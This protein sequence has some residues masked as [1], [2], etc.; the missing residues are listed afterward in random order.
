MQPMTSEHIANEERKKRLMAMGQMAA[1]LAHEIRNPLGSVE[2]YCSLLRKDLSQHPTAFQLVNEI[3][4]GIKTVDRII[5]NCL[6]FAR[7]VTPQKRTINDVP[8][9]LRESI[10]ILSPQHQALCSISCDQSQTILVDPYLIQQVIVNLVTNAIDATQEVH[11]QGMTSHNECVKIQSTCIPAVGWTLNVI[12]HG[13]GIP[14]DQ[15]EQIFDPFYT[16]K[17]R[18]TGLGLCIVHSIVRA[19]GGSVGVTSSPGQGTTVTVMIPNNT[20]GD[21]L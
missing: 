1:T 18:G 13:M 2:L 3:S 21:K 17:P 5:G 14:L 10:S 9:F 6:Q 8:G 19:H 7:D 16:T 15:L 11:G 12:D 4:K 20:P